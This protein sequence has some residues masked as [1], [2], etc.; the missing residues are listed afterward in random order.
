M[1]D[2]QTFIGFEHLEKL[3]TATSLSFDVETLQLQPEYGKMR[4]LQ[5][6]SAVRKIVV[7]IDMFELSESELARLEDFFQNGERY[8]LAHNAVFDV[9]W[10][11]AYGIHPRGQLRCSMLASKLLHNGMSNVKH[12]LK[13]VAKRILGIELSKEQQASNWGAPEL[14]EEQLLYAAKD[15]EVLCELDGELHR[16]VTQAGLAAAYSLECRALPAMAQMWRSGLPWDKEELEKVRTDY[17]TDITNLGREFLLQLDEGLPEGEK[18]PRHEDGSFNTN[19]K[20]FGSVRLGT[21]QYAGFNIGSPKQLVEKLTLLLGE[22]PIDQ[23]TDCLLYTSPSPRD[24]QKSR[25]PS[26]A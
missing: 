11:Q 3:F 20:T 21:K 7:V 18:L 12:G 19:A 14:S 17:E 15:V 23:K 6:G 25:M 2:Y 9:G 1:P 24:R 4:L 13:D 10:L 5:L 16:Q 26:S 8:W 22:T